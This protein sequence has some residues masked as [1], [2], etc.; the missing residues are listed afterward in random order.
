VQTAL[1]AVQAKGPVKAPVFGPYSRSKSPPMS[2][3]VKYN[4]AMRSLEELARAKA[5]LDAFRPLPRIVAAELRQRFEVR[6]THHSTAIEGNTLTQSETQIVLEK[7]LTIGG[8][9]V[10]EHMEVIGHKEALDFVFEIANPAEPIGEREI[11]DIHSLVM[12]GQERTDAGA[13]RRLNVKAAGTDFAYP[14][15]LHVPELM[16]EF[17]AWL[18]DPEASSP[19]E[20]AAE[21]HLRFVTIHP[22]TDGN[23]RVG[24][25]LMNLMLLRAG[26][27]IAVIPSE[28]RVEYID[29]LVEEQQYAGSGMLLHLVTEAVI[30]SLRETLEACLGSADAI[31]EKDPLLLQEVRT[32]LGGQP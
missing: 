26:Y 20:R 28:R 5:W 23:G 31:A 11:R 3:P 25:L 14:D 6:L 21:A 24:R 19:V 7:G 15:H 32:W 2:V 10:L 8:K 27:P 18:A 13:Y 17:T 12:K 1:R 16:A 9:S 30:R 4:A 29:S 22:F